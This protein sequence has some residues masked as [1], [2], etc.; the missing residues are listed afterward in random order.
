MASNYTSNYGLCQ[1]QPNDKVLRTEFNADNAKIDAALA[2]KASASAL[3]SLQ[4]TVNGLSSGKADVSALNNLSATVAQHTTALAGKGNCTIYTTS[5]T[6]SGASGAGS[7]NSVTFPAKPEVVFISSA[8]GMRA[9]LIQG[10][11]TGF[12]Q[13]GGSGSSISLTWSGTSLRWYCANSAVGQLNEKNITYLV[14]AL[15]KAG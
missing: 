2:G 14:V 11:Q 7:P 13:S 5:Y 12:A 9:A 10:Q 8:G 15:I 1:W 4:S 3:S 6:G